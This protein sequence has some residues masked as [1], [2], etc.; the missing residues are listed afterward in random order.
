[1]DSIG[2][3]HEVQAEVTA[4]CRHRQAVHEVSQ[5][6]L[7]GLLQQ[8]PDQAW[9]LREG[10]FDG[11]ISQV[12]EL[13]LEENAVP[14]PSNDARR[15]RGHAVATDTSCAEGVRL[16]LLLEK[17]H[18]QAQVPAITGLDAVLNLFVRRCLCE[19]ADEN[20]VD[21]EDP[22][23]G[24]HTT[25]VRLSVGADMGDHS[26]TNALCSQEFELALVGAVSRY[27][28]CTPVRALRVPLDGFCLGGEE[29]LRRGAIGFSRTIAEPRGSFTKDHPEESPLAPCSTGRLFL[30]LAIPILLSCPAQ[31][32]GLEL[33]G[34]GRVR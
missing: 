1:M 19:L 6:H 31:R 26:T 22:I 20:V 11:L 15:A 32:G 4:S 28:A 17:G 25:E 21:L 24:L 33:S 2:S 14:H 3:V 23:T 9:H 7:H 8:G 16:D 10:W 27:R 12:Q 18:R 34:A 30:F 29:P 13:P 5:E